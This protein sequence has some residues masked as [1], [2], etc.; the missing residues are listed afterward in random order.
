[1]IGE[2]DI[3]AMDPEALLQCNYPEKDEGFDKVKRR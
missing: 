2:E 3:H 1:M